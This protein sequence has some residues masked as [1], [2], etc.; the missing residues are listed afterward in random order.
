ME[1]LLTEHIQSAR[2]KS[3]KKLFLT[4]L[5]R[6]LDA[7]SYEYQLELVDLSEHADNP[8]IRSAAD[9]YVF[10]FSP[11]AE[12]HPSPFLHATIKAE[13]SAA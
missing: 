10:R 13:Q 4:Y 9:S 11:A 8:D 7:M 3:E 12:F 6:L 5:E 1:E 2:S